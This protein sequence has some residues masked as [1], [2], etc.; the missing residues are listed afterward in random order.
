MINLEDD[1]KL[2]LKEE[3]TLKEN[4]VGRC[5]YRLYGPSTV[6][7]CLLIFSSMSKFALSNMKFPKY[8]EILN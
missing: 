2:I 7:V 1:E 4:G 3:C 6:T 8:S 5:Y